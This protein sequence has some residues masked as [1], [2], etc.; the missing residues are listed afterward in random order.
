[1]YSA[2]KCWGGARFGSSTRREWRVEG[3]SV[4]WQGQGHR[5]KGQADLALH[6]QQSAVVV[7]VGGGGGGGAAGIE[8]A[9]EVHGRVDEVVRIL[10]DLQRMAARELGRLKGH[11]RRGE[12]GARQRTLGV[13]DLL[14][15]QGEA[16]LEELDLVAERAVVRAQ[17]LYSE[18]VLRDLA[19]QRV[20]LAEDLRHDGALVLALLGRGLAL[21]R[22]ALR[23]RQDGAV[24]KRGGAARTLAATRA[25]RVVVLV[26][27]VVRV[28]MQVAKL[29]LLYVVHIQAGEACLVHVGG[30][31]CHGL[32]LD[33]K[34]D[35]S[36]LG[37]GGLGVGHAG[38]V[39]VG[40]AVLAAG[41]QERGVHRVGL[42][43]ALEADEVAYVGGR[44]GPRRFGLGLARDARVLAGGALLD[45]AARS[46][47]RPALLGLEPLALG[48][49][50]RG[51]RDGRAHDRVGDALEGDLDTEALLVMVARELEDLEAHRAAQLGAVAHGGALADLAGPCVAEQAQGRLARAG[52]HGRA[53][54]IEQGAFD[55]DVSARERGR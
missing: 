12:L 21:A 46:I 52:A 26:V 17:L 38:R 35:L 15:Q 54:L 28:G 45:V 34:V 11:E 2:G 24:G 8:Q 55:R 48:E 40:R 33:V 49:D 37:L 18:L 25:L 5:S 19:L 50:E 47:F 36:H 3:Q 41:S 27:L 7:A 20:Q 42:L 43:D 10:G 23:G 16:I 29:R 31:R 51:A 53:I 22:L 14:G 39:V 13:Q 44:G 32:R 1:M 6:G 4:G 9:G 30:G